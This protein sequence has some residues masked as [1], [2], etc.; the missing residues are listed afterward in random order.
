MS[1][2]NETVKPFDEDGKIQLLADLLRQESVV[3]KSGVVNV[4]SKSLGVVFDKRAEDV[5]A[6][7]TYDAFK[8]GTDILSDVLTSAAVV[9][10][11]IND[12]KFAAASNEDK[13]SEDFRNSLT[14]DVRL[15]TPGGSTEVTAN[16][17][18]T[19]RVPGK[20]D[21]NG[22]PVYSTK[23]GTTGVSINAKMRIDP[24]L[25][26]HNSRRILSTIEEVSAS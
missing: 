18:T 7:V 17:Q 23:Y 20:A 13:A 3:D 12:E 14:T 8:K 15:K 6:D 16:F 1:K 2:E 9:A 4:S 5:G 22:N 21:D 11:R 19:H 26:Q 24:A 10:H 25:H